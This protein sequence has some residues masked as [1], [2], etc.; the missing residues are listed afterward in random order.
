MQLEKR[1]QQLAKDSSPTSEQHAR[2][3]NVLLRRIEGPAILALAKKEATPQRSQHASVWRE[4][5]QTIHAPAVSSFFDQI[6][7]LLHPSSDVQSQ[8]KASLFARLSPPVPVPF[9][10]RFYKWGAAFI[11]VVLALRASPLLFLAPQSIANSSVILSP[12][13]SGVALSSH[14][15][16]QPVTKELELREAALLR[17]NEGE[18]TIILHDDGNVRLASQSTIMLNDVTD[19]L[20]TGSDRSTLTLVSGKIWLQGLLP[21]QLRGFV[22]SVP[23]GI[24]T[25][26]G[27]SVS[28]EVADGKTHVE[29][30]DRHATVTEHAHTVSLVAGEYVDLANGAELIAHAL[31]SDDYKSPWIA[32]NLERDAVH[33]RE[34]AQVQQERRAAEAGILPNSPFYT[35]KRVAEN[36][37]VLLTLDPQAKV[38]KRLQQASTRLNEAAALIANG[39]SGAN[40]ALNEY[41]QTLIDVAASGSGDSV[42]QVRQQITENTAQLSA[43]L[44]DDEFYQLKK[45]VLEASAQLSDDQVNQQDVSGTLLVD[46]LDVLQQAIHNKDKV[47]VKAALEKLKPYLST[48]QSGTGDT[49]K[50]DVRKEALS[51]LSDVAT[52]LK[53]A[54]TDSGSTAVTSD[55]AQQIATY[56]PPKEE[57]Q[58]H[59]SHIVTVKAAPMT[60]AEVAAAV[61]S[62]LR[63]IFIVYKMPQSRE[64]ALRV[65]MKRFVGS[66]DEGRYLRKLY[67]DLPEGDTI[68]RE[69]VRHAIQQLREKQIVEGANG[70]EN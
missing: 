19:H 57:V 30:W 58:P 34:M 31:P 42:M 18:A 20:T 46:T 5:L 69:L 44:P 27:G 28:V 23:T 45:T 65:D 68:L 12:T 61:Q 36:F 47:Q 35:V 3:R 38:Q 51:L 6:R 37:D 43:A 17:T 49:L 64:N 60:D 8:I 2:V 11:I 16:W 55:L 63:R 33:Q 70:I 21:D 66:A 48:L 54:Q 9:T 29:V 50:P 40:I 39:D 26:H 67:H 52:G 4:I 56:L 1:L 32:Q 62:T 10:Q 24:V 13:P 7:S 25:V 41:K 14:G 15:L 22:I 53:D 59:V